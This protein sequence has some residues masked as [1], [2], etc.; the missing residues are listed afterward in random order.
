MD[1]NEDGPKKRTSLYRK[2]VEVRWFFSFTASLCATIAGISLTFGI[3][4]CRETRRARA[5]MRKSMLQAV[6]NIRD[7]FEDAE[8]WV[9][10]IEAQNRIY[11][12]AD[13]LYTDGK[14]IPDSI[15]EQFRYSLPYIRLSA[16]DHEFEKIFRGSYQ[17]WQ[18]RN[19]NDSTAFYIGLCYDG[20][21]TVETTCQA[22]SDGML[23]QIG[24]INSGKHFYRM[25]PREWTMALLTDSEF[26]YF[27][28]VRKVKS[29][30]TAGILRQAYS[31]YETH[32]QG[33]TR[34]LENE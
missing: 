3:N 10:R 15:C 20:L 34:A 8:G 30:I 2:L 4:S 16:F 27:M 1:P 12:I 9:G 26:Q 19:D 31:D 25:E 11:E 17:L 32:L 24:K 23:E 28:S 21:N 6:D 7:R 29:A 22:L 5:E 33:L 13:S 14:E 18:L